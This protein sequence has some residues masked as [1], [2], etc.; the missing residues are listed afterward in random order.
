MAEQ[1]LKR[2]LGAA[3]IT[4]MAV[5]AAIG[6]VSVAHAQDV[7]QPNFVIIL[8]DDAALMDFGVYGGEARTPHIDALA[9][10]G[11][12]F[13]QYR[14]SPLC[15]P[16]RAMLLTGMDN[17]LTGVATIPEVL[18]K[19]HVGQDG[20]TMSLEPGVLTLA[21]RLRPAGYRTLMTGKWHMGS[22]DGDLPSDHGFD[23]SF[24]LDASGADN[25]E[26]KSYM[27]FYHDAPWYE[28]GAA[29]DLPEDF[30]SSEFIVDKMIDY[31][32]EGDADR[33]FMAFLGFQAIHI[34]V[35][36]PPEFT[37]NYDGVYDA[38]WRALR[39]QR[40]QTAKTLGLIP[41]GAPL[42]PMP[43]GS[44]D[45]AALSDK[46]RELYIARMQVNAG[47]MEAM[48]HHIGRFVAHLKQTGDY[49][50]TV[51]VITSDNGP[52]PNRGDDDARL[53]MWMRFNG[54][55][56]DLDGMG[57][58]GSWGFIGPEWANAAA[59][60]GA[61]YKFYAAEGGIRVPLIMAGPGIAP[62]RVESMALVSD[63]APT[64]LDMIASEPPAPDGDAMT[65]RSLLPVL[66]GAEAEVYGDDEPIG[67]E[68]S[69]NSALYKGDYKITRHMAPVGDATWRLYNIANDPGETTDLSDMMPD[70]K[71][72]LIADYRAY[73]EQVGVLEMPKG[74][75]SHE[76]VQA[77]A[78]AKLRKR[79]WWIYLV[80]ALL[81]LG[82]AYAIWRIA[83]LIIR[84]GRA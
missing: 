19:E 15:S 75:N 21:D 9:A 30:Y 14:T 79:F 41:E 39:E 56:V 58:R 80:G 6:A 50:N 8:V 71:T 54:Y 36:A 52:E 35:Q 44:R 40:H 29:A 49:D 32:G 22:G 7:T 81:I 33:P 63:V 55:H 60:P 42:A 78:I 23:R 76:Q 67:M 27:P 1:L 17:H 16:S 20:Y 72:E 65:G 46:D 73:A 70:K 84:S 2:C 59:S 66:T 57:E 45:W 77:N 10:R 4:Q 83:R 12:M 24:A 34:P 69:G 82:I 43:E 3:I 18:P 13:T 28:D 37:A 31:L 26:D 5:L 48:D 47:M 61:L 38:G 64:L 74:Y 62:Q 53:A 51:F 25:W 11:A 68:V